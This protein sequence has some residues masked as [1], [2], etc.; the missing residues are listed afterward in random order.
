MILNAIGYRYYPIITLSLINQNK[1]VHLFIP[2]ELVV[3]EMA[4]DDTFN[5]STA[6]R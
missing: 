2:K 6:A 5:D 4:Q 3:V 1:M